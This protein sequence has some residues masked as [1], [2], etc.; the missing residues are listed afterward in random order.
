MC[1]SYR[2]YLPSDLRQAKL[3]RIYRR[4]KQL[5][6]ADF[7]FEDAILSLNVSRPDDSINPDSVNETK[8]KQLKSLYRE[9]FS[10][11]PEMVSKEITCDDSFIPLTGQVESDNKV[12]FYA[13]GSLTDRLTFGAC[14]R[15]LIGYRGIQ[16]YYWCS[17]NK[18]LIEFMAAKPIAANSSDQYFLDIVA[19]LNCPKFSLSFN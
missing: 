6:I 5:F 1:F 3:V 12:V 18:T 7:K 10:A 2:C 14:A 9:R 8:L 16:T 15:D 4:E 13:L 17:K 11:Y 19:S